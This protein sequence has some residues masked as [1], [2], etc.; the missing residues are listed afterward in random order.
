MTI[1]VT[2]RPAIA[3]ISALICSASSGP[4]SI[5]ARSVVPTRCV[6]VPVCVNG[7]GLFASTRV[8]RGS[9]TCGTS[10]CCSSMRG[11]MACATGVGKGRGGGGEEAPKTQ[12][13]K[14]KGKKTNRNK[15]KKKEK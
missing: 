14:K 10:G 3:T 5:T 4:G 9:S 2:G 1:A 7:D 8:T 13:K 6:C 11:E 15:K 12:N